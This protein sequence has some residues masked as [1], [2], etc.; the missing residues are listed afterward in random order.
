MPA[1]QEPLTAVRSARGAVSYQ[2]EVSHDELNKVRVVK[3]SD[4]DY[5]RR[6]AGMQIA[7]WQDQWTRKEQLAARLRE[8]YLFE[9][10]RE[11]KKQFEEEQKQLAGDR[12]AEA[13]EALEER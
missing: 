5:V 7:Q 4:P 12:T 8:K 1:R 6:L 2:I 3:G 13:K 11:A 10:Q 9:W